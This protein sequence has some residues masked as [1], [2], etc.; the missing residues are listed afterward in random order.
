MTASKLNLDNVFLHVPE[1]WHL[2]EHQKIFLPQGMCCKAG[3]QRS[4]LPSYG[5]RDGVHFYLCV[6]ILLTKCRNGDIIPEILHFKLY[7][8]YLQ[9]NQFYKS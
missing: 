1:N 9:L 6:K 8:R 3:Q 5:L 2:L 7:H 4:R